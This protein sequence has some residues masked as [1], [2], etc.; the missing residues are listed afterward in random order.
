M[1]FLL[2]VNYRVCFL[3][4]LITCL[5]IGLLLTTMNDISLYNQEAFYDVNLNYIKTKYLKTENH[6]TSNLIIKDDIE[7]IKHVSK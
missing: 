3:K 6:T 1:A 5:V 7:W 2:I 4:I